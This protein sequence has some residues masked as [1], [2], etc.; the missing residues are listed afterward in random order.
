MLRAIPS[1]LGGVLVMFGAI[2]ILFLLPWLHTGKIRSSTYRVFYKKFFWLWLGVCV[3]LTWLGQET[4][5]G[6]KLLLSR[7][8]TAWYFIHFL[9]VLPVCGWIEKPKFMPKSIAEALAMNKSKKS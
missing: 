7:I 9:V 6:W 4:P 1:K 3:V 8:L 5:E 2:M